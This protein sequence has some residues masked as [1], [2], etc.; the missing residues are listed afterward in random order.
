MYAYTVSIGDYSEFVETYVFHER[1]FTTE[2]FVNMYNEIIELNGEFGWFD[3]DKIA[4]QLC[5][6]F[7]FVKYEKIC[8]VHTNEG[9]F[10][11]ASEKFKVDDEGI[12]TV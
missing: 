10:K 12:V 4:G 5:D 6:K 1:K 11:K 2:E 9:K 7:G 3:Y 8:G